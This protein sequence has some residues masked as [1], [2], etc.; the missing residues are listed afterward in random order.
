MGPLGLLG[1]KGLQA[2]QDLQDLLA[3]MDKGGPLDYQVC[4]MRHY[5]PDSP[6]TVSFHTELDQEGGRGKEMEVPV[7]NREKRRK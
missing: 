1:Y 5:Y 7:S 3:K 6:G 2:L 4:W